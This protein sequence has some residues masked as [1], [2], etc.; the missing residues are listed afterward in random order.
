MIGGQKKPPSRT[1]AAILTRGRP[2]FV[3]V[4]FPRYDHEGNAIA[5]VHLRLLTLAEEQTALAQA[6]ANCVRLTEQSKD[7][8]SDLNDL[9][10]NE[11]MIEILALACRDVEDPEKLFF[12]GGPHEVRLFTSD[13]IGVLTSQYARLK[14]ENPRVDQMSSQDFDSLVQ[15]LAKDLEAYPF[16]CWPRGALD[17]FTEQCVR[18]LASGQQRNTPTNNLSSASQHSKRRIKTGKKRRASG[19]HSRR[20]FQARWCGRCRARHAH[21]ESIRTACGGRAGACAQ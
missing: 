5:K 16:S 15:A 11:R 9:E 13:E 7:Y 3:V 20:Q 6:R 12:E 8:K 18:S 14:E 19:R 4:D 2:P 21:R 17:R 10:H 1:V